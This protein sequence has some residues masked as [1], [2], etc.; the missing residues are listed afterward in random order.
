MSGL[1]NEYVE[2]TGKKIL[3]KIFLGTFPC[4][5]HPKT[6]NKKQFCLVF[7]LSKHDTKGSHFIAVFA[8]EK[9]IIYFDPF[10][11]KLTNTYIK[12]FIKNSKIGRK[13]ITNSKCIQSCSSIF[14][15][16]FCLGFLLSQK[17]GIKL[18]SFTS[19]FDYNNLDDNDQKIID[20][21]QSYI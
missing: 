12:K 8:S 2:K 18:K 15:G 4:D 11:K 7:N 17:N 21:I 6:K 19:I 16:F 9:E 5:L 13:Q 3:G 20:F 1:T 10:G 14:C